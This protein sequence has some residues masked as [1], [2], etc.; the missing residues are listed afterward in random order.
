MNRQQK[1]STL[2][3][4]YQNQCFQLI[5]VLTHCDPDLA[6]R[7]RLL[8]EHAEELK[9]KR[10]IAI[11]NRHTIGTKQLYSVIQENQ[12]GDGYTFQ[13]REQQLLLSTSPCPTSD[14]ACLDKGNE[15][16]QQYIAALQNNYS[17]LK[18]QHVCNAYT[19]K[20]GGT[21][22]DFEILSQPYDPSFM[23]K[24]GKGPLP[25]ILNR[26]T[27]EP[28]PQDSPDVQAVLQPDKVKNAFLK[29]GPS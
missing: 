6:T 26:K 9:G 10:G 2:F 13:I 22:I 18:Y 11:E 19:A 1:L 27:I 16:A 20:T 3:S 25:L 21:V 23:N 28:M 5:A 24:H 7:E 29:M 8:K 15:I 14:Q 12:F 4:G 17:D